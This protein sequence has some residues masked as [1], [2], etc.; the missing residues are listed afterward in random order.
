MTK[1]R[2]SERQGIAPPP[3]RV[4]ELA[5]FYFP[6]VLNQTEVELTPDKF[7][8]NNEGIDLGYLRLGHKLGL[9]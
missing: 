2:Q 1:K 8:P 3:G 5:R 7:P 4:N 6:Y 9:V